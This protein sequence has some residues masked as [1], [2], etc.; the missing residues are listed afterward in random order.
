M[1]HLLRAVNL[2]E[3]HADS[4]YMMGVAFEAMG[5]SLEGLERFRI[6]MRLKP[7]WVQPMIASA[8]LQSTSPDPQIRDHTRAITLAKQAALASPEPNVRALDTLAAAYAVSGDF[9][10]AVEAAEL[11]LEFLQ[12]EKDVPLREQIEERLK[13]YQNNTP[14]IRSSNF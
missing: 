2:Q 3:D 6:A 12:D 14:Y 9:P 11:A 5:M 13:L 7:D 4:H 8:W 1:R 10:R